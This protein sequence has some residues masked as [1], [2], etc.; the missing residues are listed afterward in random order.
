MKSQNISRIICPLITTI[1]VVFINLSPAEA[2][3]NHSTGKSSAQFMAGIITAFSI[4]ESAHAL[5]IETADIDV[6]WELGNYN[7]PIAFVE[8]GTSDTKG[9]ALYS[10]GLVSQVVGSEIILQTDKIDKNNAFVRGMMAWNIINPIS[11][12]LDYWLIRR[13]NKETATTFQGDIEGIEHYSSES[14]ADGFALTMAA[15]AAFQGYRFL[16]TQSWA[17]EWLKGESYRLYIE[18]LPSNGMALTLEFRF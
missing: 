17:P 10:A 5:V 3:D 13:S 15:I 12:A 7:Q 8:S 9:K 18:P 16:K 4:H 11:Y 6:H 2:S 14:T 1:F